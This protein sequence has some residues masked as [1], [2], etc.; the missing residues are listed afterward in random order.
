[1]N[2]DQRFYETLQAVFGSRCR[3]FSPALRERLQKF[4][5]QAH[6]DGVVSVLAGTTPPLEL[7]K[8]VERFDLLR[9]GMAIQNN[10]LQSNGQ[11]RKILDIQAVSQVVWDRTGNCV[12]PVENYNRRKFETYGPYRVVAPPK[13]EDSAA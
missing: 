11:T 9:P 10:Y 4:Y 7:N 3:D 8:R 12:T 2:G 5:R 1:M 6:Q 13:S